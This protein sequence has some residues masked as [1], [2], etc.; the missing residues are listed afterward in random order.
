[1]RRFLYHYLAVFIFLAAWELLPRLGW[2]NPL[3]IPPL[4][5]AL[6]AMADLTVSG[7]LIEHALISSGRAL[8]GFIGAVVVALPLGLLLGGWYRNLELALEP[9]LEGF[10]QANPFILFHILLFFLGTGEATKIVSIGWM[11]IWPILFNTVAGIRNL[12]PV[13]LKTGTSFGLGRAALFRRLVLPAAAPAIFTGLRLAA[14]YSFFMLIAAEMM[15]ASSGLGW[16]EISQQESYHI[17]RIFAVAM[18]IGLLG[19]GADS[20]VRALERRLVPWGTSTANYTTG[21]P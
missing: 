18:V 20:L 8:G 10:S 12:D 17:A 1:M 13:L 6:G 7:G 16:L 15:G 21:E 14:G 11:C 5:E 4:S 19:L 3:F 9:L 2:V